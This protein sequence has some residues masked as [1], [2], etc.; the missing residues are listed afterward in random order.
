MDEIENPEVNPLT[1]QGFRTTADVQRDE[2]SWQ[3]TLLNVQDPPAPPLFGGQYVLVCLHS[4]PL[5][6]HRLRRVG[7][8]QEFAKGVSVGTVEYEQTVSEAGGFFG[9]FAPRRD[10]EYRKGVA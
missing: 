4:E 2:S 9:T 10:P 7:V 6:L 3:Q 5:A 1:V 8:G